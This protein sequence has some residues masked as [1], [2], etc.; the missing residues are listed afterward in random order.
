[1]RSVAS[2]EFS[3]NLSNGGKAFVL[4]GD[5]DL[6]LTGIKIATTPSLQLR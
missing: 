5:I 3:I 1:M 6:I 2:Q 4:N